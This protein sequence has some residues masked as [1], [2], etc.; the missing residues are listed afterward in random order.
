M[1]ASFVFLLLGVASA[2]DVS[3]V[4]KVVTML[5]DLQTQVVVEGKAE[6]KTYDKFACFCKD[7][8]AEKTDAINAGTDKS[9]DLS[10]LIEQLQN[11]R[12]Q[13]D[14]DIADLNKKIDELDK[15][16]KENKEKRAAEKATFDALH[17]ELSKGITDLTNA[18]NTLKGSRP[19]SLLSLKS[20]IKTVRQAVF[21]GDAMG[22]SPKHQQ[23]LVALLQ[24]DPEVPMQDFTFHSEEIVS[25]IEGLQSD[26]KTKLSEVRIEETKT[27]SD[28]DLQMQA[29]TDERAAAAKELKD[30][31]ELKAQK[32][33]AIAASSKELTET[34]A[35]LTDDQNY[36]K[37]LTEKCN[38]KSKEWDQRSQMRQDELTALTTALTIVKEGVATKTTEKTVRLVQNA[39]KVSPHSVVTED[40]DDEDDSADEEDLSFVQLSSPREKLSLVQTGA[41]KFLQPDSTRDRVIALLKSKSAQL[42]SPVL[43]AIATK[44]AADP[45]VKIKKLIQEL[46]ERLLQ[47]AADEANHKG[48]CDKEFGKAK[49]SR[50][51]KAEAVKTLNENLAKSEALRDKLTEEIAVLTKEIDELQSA[52][53]KTTKERNDESAENA[54]T[55]SEAQEGQ[56]AV[57]QAIG[58]LEKFYKT[59]AKAEVFVQ[60]SSRQ[61]PDMPD[62]GFE[63]ANK[64]SQSASTGILGM[65]DVIK[66][67][68][69]RTIKETEKA[70]K[71]AAK[72]FMEFETTTKVS[73]GTKKVSKSAKEGELTEV[74]ASID[75]DNTSLGEEQ[76]LLDKSIQEIVELQPACVDTGM[77]YEERVA[78]R[79][80]EIEA[81]KEALCTLDKEGPEQTEAE[82]A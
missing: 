29:D 47:E 9:A 16:M 64:G 57:E 75:E 82:C 26:F 49:Q 60:V 27:V 71:A 56:A 10:A 12:S 69:I 50:A 73:L 72:E 33:E 31:T 77:S 28:F 55:V 19:S 37:D 39:V 67:D 51:M 21:M 70:E 30:T 45:F 81:L 62:A 18:V 14:D 38:S 59:A 8:T 43:A 17:A 25:T 48:W 13:A 3:P 5:E 20:V 63:G 1:Q 42:D 23:A 79:E 54:A 36:L 65:L 76:S 2:A 7:M 24:Q 80:Q 35:T 53:D 34:S 52:L 4:E 32:M 6:A 74:N 61:V 68:F 22:H 15:S 11:D 58:V 66:S 46:I 44:A 40:S 78:K 41:K